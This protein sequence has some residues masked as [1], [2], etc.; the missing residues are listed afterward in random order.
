MILIE[1]YASFVIMINLIFSIFLY[2]S[3]SYNKGEESIKKDWRSC[4][5]VLTTFNC[6]AGGAND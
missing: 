2:L 6:F 3:I 5:K 4:S 1:N